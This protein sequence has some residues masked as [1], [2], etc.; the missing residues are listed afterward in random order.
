[1]R[2]MARVDLLQRQTPPPLAFQRVVIAPDE[3]DEQDRRA[4]D[5]AQ[6]RG[7]VQEQDA[8]IERVTGQRI[9]SG[10]PL[11]IIELRMLGDDEP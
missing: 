2:L 4:Y 7:D 10:Q 9:V 6:D 3:W 5:A 11:R 8:L 1:M